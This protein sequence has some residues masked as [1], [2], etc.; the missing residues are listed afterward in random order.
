M[1]KVSFFFLYQRG[2]NLTSRRSPE[3]Q[4]EDNNNKTYLQGVLQVLGEGIKLSS[5]LFW[6]VNPGELGAR[7]SAMKVNIHHHRDQ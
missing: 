7:S 4:D 6:V 3:N 1:V 2:V 5:A